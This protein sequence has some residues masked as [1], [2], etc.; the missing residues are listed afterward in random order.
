MKKPSDS[1]DAPRDELREKIIGLGERSLRKSYYPQLREQI[2]MLKKSEERFRSIY[3]NAVEGIFQTTINGRLLDASP[4][5]AG[6]L[7]YETLNEFLSEVKNIRDQVHVRIEDGLE[8]KRILEKDGGVSGYETRFRKKNGDV[9]W[10]SISAKI[11]GCEKWAEA[12]VQGFVVDITERKKMSAQLRQVQKMEALGALAGGVAH[13][14]N[15]ILGV[16]TGYTELSLFEVSGE[17]KL[18]KNLNTILTACNRAKELVQQILTFARLRESEKK[19]IRLDIIVKESIKML[20]AS[21]PS[22]VQIETEFNCKNTHVPADPTQ[23]HQVLMNLCTNAAHAMRDGGVLK[24][25][26]DD[27]GPD[28]EDKQRFPE[29]NTGDYVKLTVSDT[30]AGMD[31]SVMERIFDPYFTTKG[32]GEGTGLGLS[33]V[34]GIVKHHEGVIHVA[35]P[36]GE[37]ARF[38]IF[39][40]LVKSEEPPEQEETE[41]EYDQGRGTIFVIDDEPFLLETAQQLLDRLGYRVI[42]ESDSLKALERFHAEPDLFDLVIT[43]MTMPKMT[44]AELGKRIKE[45]RPDI[46]M[47]LCTGFSEQINE[48]SALEIGFHKYLMKPVKFREL[49]DIIRNMLAT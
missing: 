47:I 39:L 25:Q 13:D 33:V 38:S 8:I 35:S 27:T 31:E 32:P 15:N 24:I 21:L 22:T 46:P 40:P 37:G 4:S 41:S 9:I 12:Y 19:P 49:A 20:R 29:L 10:V 6:I 23:M 30:G 36:P 43:D 18:Y 1:S 3:E 5:L 45:I 2:E 11:V 34:H 17:E 14:F 42:T 48:K 28:F 26:M 7:G 44:G 16:I